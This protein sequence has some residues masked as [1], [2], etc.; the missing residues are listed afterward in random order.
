MPEF[1]SSNQKAKHY[2]LQGTRRRQASRCS[3]S[4]TKRAVASAPSQQHFSSHPTELFPKNIEEKRTLHD[5]PHVPK[6]QSSSAS[7]RSCT[8]AE[9]RNEG[10]KECL[11]RADH[12]ELASKTG[13]I[14]RPGHQAKASVHGSTRVRSGYCAPSAHRRN[15]MWLSI[16][17]SA[18]SWCIFH[19][20]ISSCSCSRISI[21]KS[22]V[23]R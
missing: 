10:A 4:I 13:S 11:H 1:P 14:Q 2:I 17:A 22:P 21:P 5:D 18:M 3:P 16:L 15:R 20:T 6:Q 12:Q 19:S 7:Q 23:I 8:F 9:I